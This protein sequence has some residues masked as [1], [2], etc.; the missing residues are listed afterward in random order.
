MGPPLNTWKANGTPSSAALAQNGSYA[1]MLYGTRGID[2]GNENDRYPS[3]PARFASFMPSWMSITGICAEHTNLSGCPPNIS[4]CQSLYTWA[5]A[6]WYPGS[7]EANSLNTACGYITSA[8]T[9]SSS[10]S[11]SRVGTCVPPSRCCTRPSASPSR[12][13]RRMSSSLSGCGASMG[14]GLCPSYT[15]YRFPSITSSWGA[16]ARYSA[17][18]R[19]YISSGSFEWESAE[20]IDSS[21]IRVSFSS[22][23][24]GKGPRRS[25][26]LLCA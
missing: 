1:G 10:W 19:S 21:G 9:P 6:S 8:T 4:W 12:Q 20:M 3:P 25:E 16:R 22:P 13:Y 24:T 15:R 5:R 2:T 23:G 11:A 7:G 18:S 14:D 26:T 17:G